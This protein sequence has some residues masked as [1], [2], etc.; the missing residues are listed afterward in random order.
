MKEIPANTI[1][2]Q[3]LLA[4]NAVTITAWQSAIV[5]TFDGTNVLAPVR[6]TADQPRTFGPYSKDIRFRVSAIG[7]YATWDEGSA[8]LIAQ[9]PMGPRGPAG[10]QGPP[11]I[12]GDGG[13]GSSYVFD[14]MNASAAWTIAHNLGRFPSVTV[15][16]SAGST[17]EGDVQYTDANT[18]V[19]QFS[20][21][22]AGLAYL[23]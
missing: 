8:Q 22:F 16:D 20:A 10:P 9:G 21:T 15:V 18:V 17:I 19:V 6:V 23:N 4:G 13:S 1:E 11:G 14:Q 3:T 5:E 7:C 12:Q 2:Q